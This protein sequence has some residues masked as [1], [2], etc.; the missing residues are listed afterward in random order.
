MDKS[1][2][3]KTAI[4]IFIIV[5]LSKTLGFF[6]EMMIAYRFGSGSGTDAFYVA[7]S[8]NSVI[9]RFAGA[10]LALAVIPVLAKIKKEQSDIRVK[11]Y[12]WT[13]CVFFSVI[14]T[15]LMILTLFFTEPIVR[16]FA[17]GFTGERLEMAIRLTRI[18]I[19]II[20]FNFF[21]AIFEA[22]NQSNER[23]FIPASSGLFLNIPIIGYL[24]FFHDRM[25]LEGLVVSMIIG[26]GLR[27]LYLYIPIRSERIIGLPFTLKDEYLKATMA[28]MFPIMLTSMINYINI[29]VDKTLASRLVPGSI[30]ALSYASRTISAIDMLFVASLVTVLFPQFSQAVSIDNQ[31]RLKRM[32]TYGLNCILLI[33]IPAMAGIVILHEELIRVVFMRGAFD[34]VAAGMTSSALLF[35]S[36]GIFGRGI[37]VFVNKIYFSFHDSKT[38]MRIGMAAIAL[39]IIL[40]IVLVRV[41]AHNGLAL[42]TSIVITLSM[43]AKFIL[44]KNK[45]LVIEYKKI[46]ITAGKSLLAT[47]VMAII[48]NQILVNQWIVFDGEAMIQFIKLIVVCLI[49]VS[50][51]GL[52]IYWLRV[53]EVRELTGKIHENLGKFLRKIYR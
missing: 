31:S 42:A 50:V 33:V 49:C 41:M 3:F 1:K 19:P 27:S 10:G 46:M 24:I 52:M 6:R 45:P 32:F 36:F 18:G 20:F 25:G 11:Q 48:L 38:T 35:Y 37:N 30:S 5:T 34:E 17:L 13:L 15:V 4:G 43:I 26:Y 21:Y 29:I 23:F 39:N 51:Y 7:D 8:I 12:I 16:L 9:F 2:V 47:F 28:I 22:Y 14:A 40:N 44:L 53:D